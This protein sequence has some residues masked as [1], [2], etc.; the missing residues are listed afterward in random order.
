[1]VDRDPLPYWTQGRITLLG[2]A[3]H[4]MYPRG[5]NG[6]GQAILDARALTGCLV[7]NPESRRCAEGVRA[8]EAEGGE[9]PGADEPHQSARRHP[10]RSLEAQRRQALRA[11]RGRDQRTR[12]WW[13]CRRATSASPASSA[14]RWRGVARWSSGRAAL[15]LALR[16]ASAAAAD[17]TARGPR[18]RDLRRLCRPASIRAPGRHGDHARAC[19][20]SAGRT[21]RP[22]GSGAVFHRGA[23]RIRLRAA[24]RAA[25]VVDRFLGPHGRRR[26]GVDQRRA[27]PLGERSSPGRST[28]RSG[29]SPAAA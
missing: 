3:A 7:R 8:G 12:S 28:K 13:R 23:A 9:R 19:T 16:C 15:A 10:A 1:M 2:D 20:T 17:W 5:S 24:A 18:Q 29:I 27:G 22:R 21:S 11:H 26:G 25:A 14:K 6:A 4:P